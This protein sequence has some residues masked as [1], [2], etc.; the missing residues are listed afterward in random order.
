M[1]R[2]VLVLA[3]LL[4]AACSPPA[5]RPAGVNE[6]VAAVPAIE[7]R[8]DVDRQTLAT[9]ASVASGATLALIDP[10]TGA[11]VATSLSDAAG[12]FSLSFG[13]FVPTVNAVYILEAFKGLNSGAVGSGGARVRTF[14]RFNGTAWQAITAAGVSIST[15]TTALCA[16]QGYR[17]ASLAP[18]SLIGRIDGGGSYSEVAGAS[19]A[20]YATVSNLVA[21]LLAADHDPMAQIA[22]DASTSLFYQKR[23]GNLA[24]GDGGDPALHHEFVLTKGGVASTFVWIPLFRAYQLIVPANCGAEHAAKPVGY[25]VANQPSAG[26]RDVDWAEERFGGFYAGKYEASRADATPGNPATGAGATAGSSGTLKVAQYCVPWT[27]I[28]WDAAAQACLAY[29]SHAHLLGDEEWTAL[30]V[31]ATIGGVTVYGNNAQTNPAASYVKPADIDDPDVTFLDDPTLTWSA[32]GVDRALTGSGTAS[33]WTGVTNL[34][35]HTGKNIGAFDL[36]GNVWEWTETVG[37]AQTTGNYVVADV[38]LGITAP[39]GNYISALSTDPRLRRLGLPGATAGSPAA[40]LGGDKF[41]ANASIN[42]K[43][44]RGGAWG[45]G[46]LGGLWQTH[47]DQVRSGSNGTIGF[48]PALRY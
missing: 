28:D 3:A 44:V 43:N 13:S 22:Y 25:W 17:Q 40:L 30:A 21:G 46:Q 10:A 2:L 24:P 45:D 29:D 7:G 37:L 23:V 1:K 6:A 38:I 19:A 42:A 47:L 34:T 26:T 14:I 15:G 4:L 12:V 18:S 16:I 9:L 20:E 11:A 39:T 31:W 41:V 27:N 32:N 35:S 33:A 8:L 5:G 36:N 48:R